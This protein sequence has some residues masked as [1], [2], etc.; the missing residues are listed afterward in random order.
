MKV[1]Q[2]PELGWIGVHF[3]CPQ[4]GVMVEFVLSDLQGITPVKPKLIE[5]AWS[6]I[7][8]C[9]VEGKVQTFREVPS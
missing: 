3:A 8:Q 1:I 2:Y 4:C 7:V 5:G 6:A 9:P